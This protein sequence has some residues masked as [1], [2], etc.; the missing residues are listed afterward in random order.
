[1]QCVC[2]L[3]LIE[4]FIVASKLEDG[5]GGMLMPYS[6][7]LK[8]WLVKKY[9]AKKF[10]LKVNHHFACIGTGKEANKRVRSLFN[11]VKNSFFVL[12]LT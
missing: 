7:F 9:V 4:F 1:M 12:D 5:K 8:C 10:R 3:V 6:P 2:A 11:T